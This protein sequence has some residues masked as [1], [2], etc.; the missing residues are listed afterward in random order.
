MR[1]A[2][3]KVKNLCNVWRSETKSGVFV[4]VCACVCVCVCV[5]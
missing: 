2:A 1:F 3:W 5:F 4:C